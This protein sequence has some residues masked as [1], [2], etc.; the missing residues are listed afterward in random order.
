MTLYSCQIVL[1]LGKAK[2][3]LSETQNYKAAMEF[4][5]FKGL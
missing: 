1:A 4:K 5:L 2:V 3:R